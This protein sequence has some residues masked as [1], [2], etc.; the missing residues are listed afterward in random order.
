MNGDTRAAPAI[1]LPRP[2]GNARKA[3]RRHWTAAAP[4][5]VLIVLIVGFSLVADDFLSADNMLN[6]FRS[7]AVLLVMALG[8]MIVI[9]TGGIDLS[10]GSVLTLSAFVGALLTEHTGTTDILLILPV[11]GLACG[12]INGVVV[13]YGKLPSFLVTLGGLFAFNGVAQ[14]LSDGQPV[15]LPFDG[16]GTIFEGDVAGIP[17]IGLWSLGTLAVAFLVLRYTRV[18]RQIYAIGGNERTARLVGVPVKRIKLYAF[19]ASGFFAGF[20]AIL[21]SMRTGSASPGMGDP[22]LLPAIAAVVMGGIPLSGGMG[23]PINVVLGVLVIGILT[24]GMVLAAVDPYIRDIIMG[25][26]VVLAVALTLDRAKTDV[27]K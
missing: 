2:A 9:L 20:A 10:V 26:V 7:S 5:A 25:V 4:F 19:M 22:L 1:T 27:V 17:A 12:F 24:N 16:I 11:V 18:G 15:S 6:I 3:L 23:G 8:S 21:L 13:A 14:Y